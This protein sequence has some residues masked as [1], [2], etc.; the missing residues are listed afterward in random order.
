MENANGEAE[1]C[2]EVGVWSEVF[3]ASVDFC[4]GRAEQSLNIR[5]QSHRDISYTQD[6]EGLGKL[7]LVAD[8]SLLQT[9]QGSAALRFDENPFFPQHRSRQCFGCAIKRIQQHCTIP[10]QGLSYVATFAKKY[11]SISKMNLVIA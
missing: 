7:W 6:A 2:R 5:K 8:G 10:G 4:L 9:L 1:G 3:R 11:T